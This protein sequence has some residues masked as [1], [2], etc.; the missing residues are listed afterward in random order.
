MVED[1]E[2]FISSAEA[3]FIALLLKRV[4]MQN[5]IHKGIRAYSELLAIIN[6]L[7]ATRPFLFRPRKITV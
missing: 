7:F 1:P 3:G 4:R 6:E 5:Q 2:L